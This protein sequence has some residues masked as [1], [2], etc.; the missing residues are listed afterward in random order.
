[1]QEKKVFLVTANCFLVI[2]WKTQNIRKRAKE[3][4][5]NT[6]ED[7]QVLKQYTRWS[8]E[9]VTKD[10]NTAARTAPQ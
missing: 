3:G 8:N 7:Q 5:E 4:T 1:M 2:N 10:Q 9:D 6:H